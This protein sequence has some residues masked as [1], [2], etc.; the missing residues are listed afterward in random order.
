MGLGLGEEPT[1]GYK[2]GKN[3]R[4]REEGKWLTKG[5]LKVVKYAAEGS[6]RSQDILRVL[7]KMLNK[8]KGMFCY[9]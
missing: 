4:K 6:N 9:F 1:I 8:V 2:P 3:Y 5:S 7:T